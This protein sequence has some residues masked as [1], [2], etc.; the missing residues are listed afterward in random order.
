MAIL[1]VDNL[2]Y[3]LLSCL[4]RIMMSILLIKLAALA[5][6]IDHALQMERHA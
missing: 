2:S 6:T 3:L 1:F 4:A 5:M